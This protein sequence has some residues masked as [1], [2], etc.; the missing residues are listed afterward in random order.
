M[1]VDIH[2]D[3]PDVTE[4]LG[5]ALAGLLGPG[6]LVFLRGELG[7]GKTTLVRA[8]ARALGV[9]GPVTSPTFTVAQRYEGRVP[10]AHM[11]AYRLSGASDDDEEAELVRDALGGGAVAFVEWPDAVAG[12]LPEPRVSIEMEHRGGDARLVRLAA[13][14]P[15]TMVAL[16]S[17]RDHL[18]AGHR[19]RQPERGPRPR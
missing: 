19:H 5:A 15:A 2:S 14:D 7:A 3:G 1:A 12:I 6:D 8:V 4:A 11:D 10:L 9:G 18:R 13:G 16:E 17:I